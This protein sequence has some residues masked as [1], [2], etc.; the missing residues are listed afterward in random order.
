MRLPPPAHHVIADVALVTKGGI[1]ALA[2]P[3][4]ARAAG[5][6]ISRDV[7]GTGAAPGIGGNR[8][9]DDRLPDFRRRRWPALLANGKWRMG[10]ACHHHQR[11]ET[12]ILH[13]WALFYARDSGLYPASMTDANRKI[14]TQCHCRHG[15]RA[16]DWPLPGASRMQKAQ[17]VKAGLFATTCSGSPTWTRTRDLRINSPSL[18]Q[19]SYQGKEAAFYRAR[20]QMSRF[21]P[22][23]MYFFPY[24]AA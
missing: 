19:L 9:G 14:C 15:R 2:A 13:G 7:V 23:N 10:G 4:A 16:T 1:T 11:Q 24:G 3:R 21:P 20:L 22:Q 12:D 5:A 8:L 17:P 6:A 18:Y